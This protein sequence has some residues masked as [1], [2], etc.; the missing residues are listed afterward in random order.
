M[1]REIL[2]MFEN[3]L[4]KKELKLKVFKTIKVPTW[5]IDGYTKQKELAKKVSKDAHS[6]G[7]KKISALQTY[8]LVKFI[9]YFEK[10]RDFLFARFKYEFACD[11]LVKCDSLQFDSENGEMKLLIHSK[12]K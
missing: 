12:K 3:E 7:T 5:F 1:L 10:E 4:S 9:E 11:A 2:N 8:K 6:M